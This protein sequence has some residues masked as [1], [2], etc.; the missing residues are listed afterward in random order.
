MFWPNE[1]KLTDYIKVNNDTCEVVDA[2]RTKEKE[3]GYTWTGQLRQSR[4]DYVFVS[5]YL[6]TKIMKV[7]VDWAFG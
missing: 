1:E 3:G 4:L 7:E 5:R 6:S 2:F